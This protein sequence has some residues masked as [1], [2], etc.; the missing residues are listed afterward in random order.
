MKRQLSLATRAF[1]FGSLPMVL[2]LVVSFVLV[3]KAVEGRIKGQL[4]ESLQKTEAVLSRREAEYSQRNFRVLSALTE[5]PSLKAGIGL[6]RENWDPRGQEQA[7]ATLASQLRQMGES[8]DYDLLLLEDAAEK[9]LVGV[10]GTQRARLALGS[11]KVEILAPSLIRVDDKLYEAISVPINLGPENLGTLVVGKEFSVQGWNEFGDTALLQNGKILLTTFPP[12]RTEEVERQVSTRCSSI[13]KECEVKVGNEM[14]LALPVRQETFRDAVRLISFQSIDSATNEFTESL[15]SIFPLIGG[16]GI[17]LVLLVSALAARS[18]AEP[19]VRLIAQLRREGSAGGFHGELKADYQ[20]AEVNELAMEFSRAAGAVRETERRL[21]E[22]TEEFIES[23]AQA[24]DARDPYTAGH[25]ERVSAVSTAIAMSIGL[26]AEQVEIVRIG[27]KLHDIGKIGIPDAVLR[28][29]GKL[30][31]EEYILIQRHPLIGKKIL[32]RVE[33][34]KDFLPIVELH[35]ENPNGSGYPY[36]LREDKIPIE[37]RIVHVADVYDA[38]TS[39]RAYR[40][41]M[42]EVQAWDL[43]HRGKGSL[44]DP[45]VVDALWAIVRSEGAHDLLLSGA[46]PHENDSAFYSLPAELKK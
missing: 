21:D 40:K 12:D 13:P 36:G 15:A 46:R 6:L 43:L 32:E 23:M 1:V 33:R 25:S 19:L 31:R 3:S 11:H 42:L 34:F 10:I 30:T 18:I 28:K 37:V 14:Y 44:F 35:H 20:A 16:T 2:T 5:N 22:A 9:P 26:T 39:D 45:D 27:A 41:A 24:Q 7:H 29:P 8:L 4:R 17:L 38:I